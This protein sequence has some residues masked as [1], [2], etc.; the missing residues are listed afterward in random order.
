MGLIV[1]AGLVGP[2]AHRKAA[3]RVGYTGVSVMV[4]MLGP[5]IL[6]CPV[7]ITGHPVMGRVSC[8]VILSKSSRQRIKN[9]DCH[10]L[11]ID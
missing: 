11:P 6:L 7:I 10:R 3:G 9:L 8:E 4:T 1:A 5:G 2:P